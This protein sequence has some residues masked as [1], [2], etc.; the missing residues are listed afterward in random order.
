MIFCFVLHLLIF[1]VLFYR[2]FVVLYLVLQVFMYLKLLP[3]ENY[4]LQ[5]IYNMFYPSFTVFCW[6]IDL[7]SWVLCPCPV[8][9]VWEVWTLAL[10]TAGKWGNG[11]TSVEMCFNNQQNQ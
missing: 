7:C 3:T 9:C 10:V 5:R 1:F 8:G 4:T 2:S 6:F 11:D